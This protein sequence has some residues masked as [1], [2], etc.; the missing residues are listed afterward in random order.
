MNQALYKHCNGST[1]STYQ[2]LWLLVV[3]Y[4]CFMGKF[5]F[6]T[7]LTFLKGKDRKHRQAG[8]QAGR[9]AVRQA[10]RIV[11]EYT[12]IHLQ[13]WTMMPP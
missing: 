4:Y 8:R 7:L 5:K 3:K 2:F 11:K 9:Q 13:I 6:L 1:K 10:G 12:F